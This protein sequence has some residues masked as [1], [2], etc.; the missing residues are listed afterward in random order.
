LT[1]VQQVHNMI[2]VVED[3]WPF[4]LQ[5]RERTTLIER[6]SGIGSDRKKGRDKSRAF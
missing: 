6:T 1:P 5:H 4:A 2:R 3:E